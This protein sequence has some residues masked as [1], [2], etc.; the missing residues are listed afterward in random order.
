MT[1]N[2]KLK[3]IVGFT[4]IEVLV[5]AGIFAVAAGLMTGIMITTTQV[6]EQQKASA[7][8]T[9][10]LNFVLQTI[11]S[12]VRDSSNIEIDAGVATST[13]KLRM[14]DSSKDPTYISLSDNAVQFKE[15]SSATS[16]ITN[17]KVVVNSLSFKKFTQYPGHDVV[18][19]DVTMTYNTSN[20]KSQ[21]ARTLSSAI[22]RV[23]AATF[24]SDVVPGGSY[25]YNLGQT[26]SPW[27]YIY[28]AD[29]TAVNPSYTFGNG[30][31]VGLFRGG[32]NILGFSTAGAERMRIDASGNI[33]VG[34]TTPASLLDV[35]G[36]AHLR[37]FS[38]STTGLVV[39]GSGNVGIGTVSPAEKLEVNGGI[40]IGN[41]TG[42][43]AGTIRWTG[44]AF[45]GYNGSEWGSLGGGGGVPNGSII[46]YN[47]ATCPAGWSEVTDARGRYIVGLPSS[48][49]LAST[50]G[51][52]LSNLENRAAGA[53]THTIY[54]SLFGYNAG[55]NAIYHRTSSGDY[56]QPTA[57]VVGG[58]VAGTNAP[59]IQYLV[60][61]Y[62]G[63]GGSTEGTTV[64]G[65]KYGLAVTYISSNVV[66]VQ[67]TALEVGGLLISNVS[68]SPSLAVSGANGLDT[69]SEA[70]STWYAVY[71]ITNDAGT[72]VA[73][74][75][76]T[77][78][79]SPTLPSGYTKS[80]RVGS[81]RNNA[82]SNIVKFYWPTGGNLIFYDDAIQ[83]ANNMTQTSWTDVDASAVMPPSSRKLWVNAQMRDQNGQI[84]WRVNGSTCST[85]NQAIY[86]GSAWYYNTYLFIVVDDSRIFEYI[87]SE[88]E[89]YGGALWAAGYEENI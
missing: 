89:G 85:C 46:F 21:V 73:G 53:H 69:G 15:G 34:T 86:V 4:L 42:T 56:D 2:Q 23:S 8:V 82:S 41:S 66:Q 35:A 6:G 81:V 70:A 26:G 84:I 61:K 7:E 5:Y 32:T 29:G 65:H 74:L 49:T 19:V 63:T 48:G 88:S 50:T 17:D 27:Q 79:T 54:G 14:K 80:R 33:G 9:G 72:S 75:Y 67:A 25:N 44:S 12:T 64:P 62:V 57:G 38:T 10:Q 31:G 13:L 20:P 30:T 36:T 16:T 52:A 71:V 1:K 37:G 51:S 47:G 24:D 39:N 18:S 28:M 45:E 59:Y 76:S 60:C 78:F 68:S 83:I 43:N 77:N 87:T 40:K 11:Q 55:S 58:A 3:T 22:A